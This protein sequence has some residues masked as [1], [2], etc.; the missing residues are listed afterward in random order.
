MASNVVAHGREDGT[1][2]GYLSWA[3]RGGTCELMTRSTASKRAKTNN[4]KSIAE[5]NDELLSLF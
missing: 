2:M 4:D 3:G 1:G 5:K